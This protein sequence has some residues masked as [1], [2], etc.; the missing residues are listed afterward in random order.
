MSLFYCL[1][2]HSVECKICT[3]SF[4]NLLKNFQ[5]LICCLLFNYQCSVSMFFAN[6][7]SQLNHNNI[8]L[9]QN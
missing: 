7:A 1:C 2:F 5:G 4:E 6:S 8:F 9:S 3:K